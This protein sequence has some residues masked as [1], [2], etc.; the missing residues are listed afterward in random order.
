[1]RYSWFSHIYLSAGYVDTQENSKWRAEEVRM[2][3]PG[4][5]YYSIM[6]VYPHRVEHAIRAP[7]AFYLSIL[8]NRFLGATADGKQLTSRV[9]LVGMFDSTPSHHCAG[10]Y[11][12]VHVLSLC[13]C[14][15]P[16]LHTTTRQKQLVRSLFG[17][18][19]V[20]KE[21]VFSMGGALSMGEPPKRC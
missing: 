12:Y 9:I 21:Q 3:H 8:S 13:V 7:L 16:F 15:I 20:Y 4:E 2:C 11:K 5:L 18:A 6:Y 10:M 19:L 14:H 17:D 1:V